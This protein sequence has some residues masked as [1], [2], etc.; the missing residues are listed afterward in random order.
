[1]ATITGVTITVDIPGGSQ[2]EV[3]SGYVGELFQLIENDNKSFTFIVQAGTVSLT[4]NGFNAN[5]CPEWRRL[6]NLNG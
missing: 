5:S 4:A 6:W 2:L 3:D 1:M